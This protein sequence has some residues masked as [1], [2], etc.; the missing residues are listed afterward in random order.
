MNERLNS[1]RLRGFN[2]I[3]LGTYHALPKKNFYTIK[4][5][6]VKFKKIYENLKN[7]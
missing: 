6:Y 3:E 5:Y 2:E 4:G 7:I 1:R